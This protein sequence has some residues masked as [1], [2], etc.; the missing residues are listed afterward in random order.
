M[1]TS[2]VTARVRAHVQS[3]EAGDLVGLGGDDF[4]GLREQD[5]VELQALRQGGRHQVEALRRRSSARPAP[6]ECV[7]EPGRGRGRLANAG[8]SASARSGRWSPRARI[9]GRRPAATA[10][11]ADRCGDDRQ[12]A[13]V[14]GGPTSAESGRRDHGQQPGGVVDDVA[15]HAEAAR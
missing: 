5:V 13:P 14:R 8:T 6:S 1:T 11:V 2:E 9:D 10:P 4:G 12:L 7:A 15:R 3:P